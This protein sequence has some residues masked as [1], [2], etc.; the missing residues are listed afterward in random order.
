MNMNYNRSGFL[1]VSALTAGCVPLAGQAGMFGLGGSRQNMCG[2]AAKPISRIRVGIIGLGARGG[3]AVSRLAKIKDVDI[4]ALCDKVEEKVKRH[5]KT[6][7]KNGRPAAKEFFGSEDIWK[8]LVGLDLDLVYIVTPW[9]WHTPMAVY[10]MENGKHAASEVPMATTLEECWELVETS[11][12]TGK[13]CMQLENCC[14]DFFELQTLNM[15]RQG[16]FGELTHAEGAYIHNLCGL[17]LNEKKGYQDMWRFKANNARNGNLYPTHGLGPISQCMNI[18][19][20]NKFDF[21]TSMSSQEAAFSE[22]AKEQGK[23]KYA[24]LPTY[25]GDMN[26]TLIKC[27]QGQTVM[28]QHNVSTPRPYSR[29]H[30]IQGTK[31]MARKWPDT[32][33]ALG[34]KWLTDDEMKAAKEK[35]QH[36][37]SKTMGD[38]ARKVG[39][40]GG[41]DFIMDYRLIYCLK[42]G[43][44][45]D[46]DVYDAA[47]WSSVTPL[48]V[49]SVKRNGQSMKVPDFTRGAWKTNTP[50]GIVDVDPSKLEVVMKDDGTKQL[51]VR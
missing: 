28:V 25:R 3:G 14:Y 31:G 15:V 51:N 32:K 46:Q 8:K 34:H 22:F 11:E 27:A 42:N 10:A 19:R 44:P 1:K 13:H 39:G 49:A 6:L 36:P 50:L 16:V 33:I 24:D 45:L 41:M 47:A 40:H 4:V 35:Y 9:E 38:I 29:I 26:T 37:L 18:N 20:G 5:Q 23:D 21:L 43:L 7:V 12:K 30:L 17:I 2:Y 48:S